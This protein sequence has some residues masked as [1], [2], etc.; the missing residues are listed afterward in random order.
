MKT[1]KVKLVIVI[2]HSVCMF[3]QPGVEIDI[4][5]WGGTL[6]GKVYLRGQHMYS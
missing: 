1:K 2:V 6:V 4:F 3:I 5:A